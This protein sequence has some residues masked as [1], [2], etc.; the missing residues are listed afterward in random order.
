MKEKKW[1]NDSLNS[2]SLDFGDELRGFIL[3]VIWKHKDQWTEKY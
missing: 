3:F 2:H 1:K